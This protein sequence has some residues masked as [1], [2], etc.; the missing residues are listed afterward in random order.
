MPEL[1]EVETVAEQLRR[2][3]SRRTVSSVSINRAD[4]I[5]MGHAD[6]AATLPGKRFDRIERIGKRI[7]IRLAPSGELALH[8]GMSGRVTLESPDAPA[9][10]HT[11][12]TL[13][14]D[15][16]PRELRFRDPRRFG[17][18]WYCAAGTIPDVPHM[19]RLGPDALT[20]DVAMLKA[21]VARRRQIKALLMDQRVISGLG[22]IY[23]D[24]ALHAAGI[25]PL[26]TATDID[27]RH[28]S[29][30]AA[31]IRRTL[32]RAVEHGGSTFRE[33]RNADGDPGYFQIHHRVYG[34]AGQPCH[35]CKRPIEKQQIA[36]R[37]TH[38]CPNC[39]PLPGRSR[40]S[41]A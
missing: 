18:V 38:F 17:G 2:A 24:E 7:V 14:F 11:H 1:P 12:V 26:V 40:C 3:L 9:L 39:Q 5:R 41:R 28:I 23:C 29:R 34:K 31:S 21:I 6:F 22:N 16:S 19:G 36:G 13:R 27:T 32:A 25:H 15:K 30:L 37:T 8:L 33:Y 20:I 35:T 4:Y 10:P